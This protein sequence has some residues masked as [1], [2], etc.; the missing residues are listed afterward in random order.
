MYF[1][2]LQNELFLI[3]KKIKPIFFIKTLLSLG[4]I[5]YF[6]GYKTRLLLYT[7]GILKTKKLSPI[8]ISIGNLTCGGTG[9]TP[10]TIETAR[11]FITKGYKVAILSRGYKRRITIKK[12]IL[13]SDGEEILADYET[14]GDEPYLIAKSV[15]KAI[16][17]SGTD[18]IQAA[19]SA[20]KLKAQ[21]L[22]LD[23]G[24]QYLKLY[25]NENILV[26]NGEKPFDNNY[27]LP[28]GEL[29][30]L[31]DSI[32]RATAIV[33]SNPKST[34][35]KINVLNKIKRYTDSKPIVEM[36][37]K[38]KKLK[39]INIVKTINPSEIKDKRIIAF[40]GIGNPSLFNNSLTEAGLNIFE[41]IIYADHYDYDFKDLN[42]I[43]DAAKKQNIEDIVTTE[44]DAVKI[45][46]LCES[47]PITFWHS[48]LEV[49]WNTS[50][51]FK[52]IL[53]SI[54][55]PEKHTEVKANQ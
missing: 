25:R 7:L 33:L 4:S 35:S 34:E 10:L 16:V 2:K 21:I 8:V 12:N 6:L 15:P 13:V 48:V 40:S 20:I 24:F 19:Q 52:E 11:Y 51:P 18:R 1:K 46:Y 37:Y 44:K 32:E 39:G 49:T 41:H 42:Q 17:L 36:T 27:L 53:T 9:K 43:I 3:Y 38:I 31:P 23:D 30:E 26:L 54:N 55:I 47:V 28:A 29:R 5:F 14:S 22:I 45:E 50:N